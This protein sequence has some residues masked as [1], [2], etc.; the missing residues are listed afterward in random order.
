MPIDRVSRSYRDCGSP[1]DIIQHG[2]LLAPA[3]AH[4]LA[5]AME[6]GETPELLKLLTASSGWGNLEV[7][8]EA[9]S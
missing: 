1:R 4:W 3:S 6:T 9:A 7:N 5:E 2:I 8:T